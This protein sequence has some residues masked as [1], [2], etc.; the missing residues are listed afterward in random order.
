MGLRCKNPTDKNAGN[1][2]KVYF[3]C[4]P[5]D[6]ELY[7][8]EIT[9][10]ILSLCNC[11]IYFQ[12][13][14]GEITADEN[15]FS[16][17]EQTNLFVFPVT[18]KFL[19]TENAARDIDFAFAVKNNTPILPLL[20]ERELESLFNDKCGSYHLLDKYKKWHLFTIYLTITNFIGKI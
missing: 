11:E 13:N 5:D 16:D 19:L 1:K 20:Q 3:S 10:D 9:E 17:I 8:E 2:F 15:Y 18:S 14:L 4:H 12:E 7:F 6:F